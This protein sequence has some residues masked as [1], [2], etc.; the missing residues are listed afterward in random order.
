[1]LQEEEQILYMYGSENDHEEVKR[2]PVEPYVTS[3]DSSWEK[4]FRA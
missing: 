3:S 2:Q 1:M 4:E